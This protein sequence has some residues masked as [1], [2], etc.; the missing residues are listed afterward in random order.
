MFS[1]FDMVR[2]LLR[3]SSWTIAPRKVSVWWMQSWSFLQTTFHSNE[4]SHW[5]HW[6]VSIAQFHLICRRY[7]WLELCRQFNHANANLGT[8]PNSDIHH[9]DKHLH[10]HTTIMTCPIPTP[11]GTTIPTVYQGVSL[12]WGIVFLFVCFR[13]MPIDSL[14]R[15]L[16][17]LQRFP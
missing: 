8:A 5:Y 9:S 7:L 13:G 1:C 2:Y 15:A 16:W 10:Q 17:I 12:T 11:F 6:N 14:R 4:W 3:K